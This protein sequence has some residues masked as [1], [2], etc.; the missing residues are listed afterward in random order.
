MAKRKTPKVKNL[1]EKPTNITEDELTSLQNLVNAMN[2]TQ[3]EIGS[4]ESRKHTVLHNSLQLQNQLNQLQQTFQE[5]YGQADINI[6]DGAI[7][8]PQDEQADKKD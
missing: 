3:M 1:V 4:L 7:T 5:T 2:R 8:Y 6:T